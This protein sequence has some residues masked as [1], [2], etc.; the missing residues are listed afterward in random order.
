MNPVLSIIIPSHCDN[1]ECLE[2]VK[3]IYAT[4]AAQLAAFE[5][6]IVLVDDCSPEPVSKTIPVMERYTHVVH[7][8]N[9]YRIGCGPSRYV[10][11]CAARGEWLLFVDSHMRFTPG[12]Y[13]AWASEALRGGTTEL[14]SERGMT[15]YCGS[16]LGLDEK[17]MDVTKAKPYFAASWNFYGPDRNKA[18]RQPQVFECIWAPEQAGD[19]YEV[20][21]C[22]GAC[23]FM[24]RH[25]FM[26]LQPLRHLKNWA[27][28][29]QELSLK[30][31]LSGGRIV[32]LKNV[33]IAHKF[34]SGK[35]SKIAP[36]DP[37][38]NKLFVMHTCLPPHLALRL[39]KKMHRG[40]DLTTALRR[41]HDDWHIV[42][43]ERA[44]NATIFTRDFQWYLSRFNL[45]FPNE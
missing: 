27:G 7:L 42:E 45:S 33:R 23:Y 21:A 22:M 3:S 39:Q 9:Q 2:T 17:M 6:E 8:R 31:W 38:R 28:D 13:E 5:V 14:L 24:T 1:L 36:S 4:T 29:E 30:A 40:G 25:W 34:K 35:L 18:I 43:T 44:Y 41:L 26:Q 10:G 16:C 32:F 12:W 37:I 15:L 20:S 11:A 19:A